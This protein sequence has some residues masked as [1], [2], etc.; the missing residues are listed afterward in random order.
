MLFCSILTAFAIS[1]L[2]EGG[3]SVL[4]TIEEGSKV[5]F[6]MMNIIVKFAPLGALGAMDGTVGSFGLH[7][8]HKLLSLMLAFYVTAGLLWALSWRYHAR[9]RHIADSISFVH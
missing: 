5:C 9:L 8:L 7:S 6:S 2:P 4:K 1:L 3:Q